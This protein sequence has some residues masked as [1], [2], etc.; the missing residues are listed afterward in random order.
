VAGYHDFNI[1]TGGLEIYP[2]LIA[3]EHHAH[4]VGDPTHSGVVELDNLLAGGPLRGTTT[5]IAGPAG[6]GKTTLA[7]QYFLY[8]RCGHPH[9][10][11]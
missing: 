8:G 6:A 5:L 7:L 2:R 11:L 4:F 9:S 10:L 1:R 3:T